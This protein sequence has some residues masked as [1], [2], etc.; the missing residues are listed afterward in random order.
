MAGCFCWTGSPAAGGPGVP[1]HQPGAPRRVTEES[2]RETGAQLTLRLRVDLLGNHG[3]HD[4]FVAP[5]DDHVQGVL[6]LDDVADVAGGDHRLPV[7]ADDDV[8]LLEPPPATQG[9]TP[10]SLHASVQL[11]RE[12]VNVAGTAARVR[13]SGPR[14]NRV[15]GG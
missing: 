12:A 11:P 2:L 5:A 9:R 14:A 10:V 15:G 8:I 3:D 4:V 6:L 7:D 13:T 1:C